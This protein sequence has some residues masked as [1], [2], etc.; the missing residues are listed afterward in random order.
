MRLLMFL[1]TGVVIAACDGLHGMRISTDPD[2][3]LDVP[4]KRLPVEA[5][6][7]HWYTDVVTFGERRGMA[8]ERAAFDA[9]VRLHRPDD[10]GFDAV[11]ELR[12]AGS[13][14]VLL[15]VSQ[16]GAWRRSRALEALE[17]SLLTIT[18]RHFP[19]AV[20]VREY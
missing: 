16:F 11:I 7:E 12:P 4:A 19:S 9:M 6:Y 13:G 8:Y 15:E 5:R 17:D 3:D 1:T 2:C 18:R 10:G 14:C 20:V